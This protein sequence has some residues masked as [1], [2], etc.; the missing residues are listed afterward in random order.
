MQ[1]GR[2]ENHTR[3]LGAPV[4]WDETKDGKCK[5]LVIRDQ[6]FNGHNEMVSAWFPTPE[7]MTRLIEGAPLYLGIL[8]RSHPP[9]MLTVGKSPT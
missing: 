5:A 3:V 8:G 2:I 1:S 9:V 4:D 6:D 7:E